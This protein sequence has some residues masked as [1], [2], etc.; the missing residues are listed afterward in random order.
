MIITIH[1]VRR[2]KHHGLAP[3]NKRDG[4]KLKEYIRHNIINNTVNVYHNHKTG[5]MVKINP[6]FIA[7]MYGERVVTVY[8]NNQGQKEKV[9]GSLRQDRELPEFLRDEMS[10]ML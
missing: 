9:I 6:K 2:L 5:A 4:K 8:P 1:A 7:V 10:T 3:R